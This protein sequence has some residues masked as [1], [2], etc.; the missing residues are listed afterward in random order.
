MPFGRASRLDGRRRLVPFERGD[1]LLRL[2]CG[3]LALGQH[4][5][6][7]LA[8]FVHRNLSYRIVT[9]TAVRPCSTSNRVPGNA[10]TTRQPVPSA[11]TTLT[12]YT[13]QATAAAEYGQD[14]DR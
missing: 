4:V 9:S 13:R 1:E 3:D 8:L 10:E 12:R 7:V 14:Q 11:R 5:E 2:L 6:D